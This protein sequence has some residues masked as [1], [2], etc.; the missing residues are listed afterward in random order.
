M[1]DL[2][3][4]EF[5]KVAATLGLSV[6]ALAVFEQACSIADSTATNVSGTNIMIGSSD[7]PV[8]ESAGE[9]YPTIQTSSITYSSVEN[10]EDDTRGVESSSNTLDLTGD[11]IE[12]PIIRMKHLA[13]R[14]GFGANDKEL[15]ELLQMGEEAATE[16]FLN[17]ELIDD[18]D[19][20]DNRFDF[21]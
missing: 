13:R 21:Y 2:D 4:R 18:S 16:W 17:Y 8:V 19:I 10:K 11:I 5:L 7:P 20:E 15:T 6:T 14:A 9:T 12:D 3:R 1:S